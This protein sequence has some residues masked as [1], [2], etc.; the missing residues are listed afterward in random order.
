MKIIDIE[1]WE[2]APH[3]RL[4]KDLAHPHY[5]VTV[6]VEVGILAE[7][8]K[9]R[10]IGLFSCLAYAI[11][12]A[13]NSVPAFRTRIQGERVVEYEVIHPSYAAPLP[14]ASQGVFGYATFEFTESLAEFDSR[15]KAAHVYIP[16]DPD[17]DNQH[18]DDLIYCSS[19]PWLAFTSLTHAY[20]SPADSIPRFTVGKCTRRGGGMEAPVCVQVHHGVVDGFPLGQF[21]EALENTCATPAEELV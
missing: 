20:G 5:A 11:A 13:A 21:F 4:F 9:E 8:A 7:S 16:G 15:R 6:P 17:D 19:L 12:V 10:S 3:Y 1:S 14:G 2:R 18:R